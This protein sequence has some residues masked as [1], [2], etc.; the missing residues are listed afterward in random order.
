MP[1]MMD[2]VQELEQL[3]RQALIHQC[4]R[5]APDVAG[6]ARP[7]ICTGC[8]TDIP[9]ARMRILENATTCVDCQALIERARDLY[10]RG[11]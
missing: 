9:L 10:V 1:D 2:Q 5:R 6:S 3:E 4:G 8:G 11:G 7:G